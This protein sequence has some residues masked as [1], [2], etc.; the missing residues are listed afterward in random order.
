[1]PQ[2]TCL[3]VFEHSS[4][5]RISYTILDIGYI[6]NA[7]YLIFSI[8]VIVQYEPD[9]DTDNDILCLL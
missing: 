5:F 1:M 2:H 3:E 6:K 8:F 4:Q 7:W 9:T